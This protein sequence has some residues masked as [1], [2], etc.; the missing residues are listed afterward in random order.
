MPTRFREPATACRAVGHDHRLADL[1]GRIAVVTGGASGIGYFT[2]EGLA[3]LGARVVIAGR[4]AERARA[5][6]RAI[7]A[8]VP[9]ASVSFQ[10]LDLADLASVAAAAE[11]MAGLPSLDVF[12]ANAGAIGYPDHVKPAAER[13]VRRQTTADGHELFWGTNFLGHYA[14]TAALLPLVRA[15]GGR[16]VFVGSIGDRGAP[17]PADAVPPPGLRASDLAKYGQSKLATATLMGEL[18]RRLARHGDGVASLGAHPGTA[19]DFLSPPR[20]GVAINQPDV[21]RIMRAPV[22]LFT[23]GKHEGARPVLTAAA[24][25]GAG[26]G[27]CWGPRWLTR[28]RPARARSHPATRDAAAAARLMD[29]AA[30]LTGLRLER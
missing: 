17:L 24:C 3:S 27:E 10:P 5:A 20:D 9:G 8:E 14:L 28:G 22:R 29:A 26:N 30:D 2:A 21:A 4:N 7:E 19:V 12:V 13:G 16:C 15:S 18:A 6:R 25:P 11:A 1:T 23:H